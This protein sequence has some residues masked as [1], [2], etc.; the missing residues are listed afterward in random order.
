M[1]VLDTHALVWWTL[2]PAQL[3]PAARKACD[4]LQE[5]GAGVS[6]ISIWE[7]GIKVK[8]GQLDIGTTLPD[9]V[10]RLRELEWLELIPVT[11]E[12]WMENVGLPWDHRDPADRT[13]VATAGL[14]GAT[15]ITRDP[16]IRAF[17]PNTLW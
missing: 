17:Y 3:S 14:R 6:S 7:V 11:A 16:V 15:L 10:G 9:Y 1:V 13:I 2:D 12:I 5:T 8:R 4:R